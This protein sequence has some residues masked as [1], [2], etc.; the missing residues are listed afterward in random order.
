[1]KQEEKSKIT[2]HKIME[3]AIQEFGSYG[4]DGASLNHVCQKGISKGLLYHHFENKDAIYMACVTQCFDAFTDFLNHQT[5]GCH[6]QLYMNARLQFFKENPYY[7]NIFFES[8]LKPP[9]HLWAEIT[10]ARKNFDTVNQSFYKA[11]LDTAILRK[12]VTKKEALDYFTLMQTMFNGY[13]ASPAFDQMPFCDIISCHEN[14][15]SK[16]LEFMLYGIAER[17][18]KS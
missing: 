15:L 3:G 11:M 9:K 10:G 8:V 14:K 1:M 13:F 18:V 2:Y 16:L 4:Y 5:I 7:K 6:L 17:E 12:G